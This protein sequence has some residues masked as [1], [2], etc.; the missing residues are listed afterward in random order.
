MNFQDI[1]PDRSIALFVKHIWVFEDQNSVQTL[2]QRSNHEQLQ[3]RFYKGSEKAVPK[4][5]PG[6]CGGLYA[7]A[8][9]RTRLCW[10][11]GL[12]IQLMLS[13]HYSQPPVKPLALNLVCTAPCRLP[14]FTWIARLLSPLPSRLG[15]QYSNR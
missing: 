13:G 7:M 8:I 5:K 9:I 2:D 6:R 10:E 12:H 15:L 1:V 3:N 11:I 14:S 4:D